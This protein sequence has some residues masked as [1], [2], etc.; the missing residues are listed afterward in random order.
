MGFVLFGVFGGSD[1]FVS[2][3]FEGVFFFGV[4]FRDDNDFVCI[5]SFGLYDIKVVEVIEIDDIDCFVG[6]GVVV[7]E[8]SV[9]GYIIV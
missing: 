9:G 1:E 4:C 5:E 7:F 2:V 8:G 6:I 3:Y